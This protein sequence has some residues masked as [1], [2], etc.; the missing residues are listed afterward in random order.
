MAGQ[1]AG[2]A[3]YNAKGSMTPTSSTRL[4]NFYDFNLYGDPSIDVMSKR[5]AL[6]SNVR[7]FTFIGIPG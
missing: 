5:P 2:A 3:L 1:T 6:P 4:M 7:V